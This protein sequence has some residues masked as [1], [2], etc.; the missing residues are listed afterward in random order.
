MAQLNRLLKKI[1]IIFSYFLCCSIHFNKPVL[2][3][4]IGVTFVVNG[5]LI[6]GTFETVIGF[7]VVIIV[8]FADDCCGGIVLITGSILTHF[9]PDDVAPAYD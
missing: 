9:G 1:I 4:V 6:T 8:I 5:I 2:T 7:D 3:I